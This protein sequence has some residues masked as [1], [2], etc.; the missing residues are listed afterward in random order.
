[1][2]EETCPACEGSGYLDYEEGDEICPVCGGT[3][4]VMGYD[5][6]ED[7]GEPLLF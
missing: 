2:E 6:T 1:M 7:L 5:D 3:G 4:A